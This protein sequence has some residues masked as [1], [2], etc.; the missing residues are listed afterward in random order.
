VHIIRADVGLSTIP[1][2]S[3]PAFHDIVK[4]ATHTRIT[5]AAHLIAQERPKELTDELVGYLQSLEN[6]KAGIKAKL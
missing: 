3:Y 6:S 5:G 4:H 2:E 1:E